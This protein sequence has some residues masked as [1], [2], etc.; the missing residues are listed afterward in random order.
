MSK[1]VLKIRLTPKQKAADAS[2]ARYKILK[3]GRRVGKTWFEA[4]TMAKWSL[5]KRQGKFWYV[6]R[7]LGLG[8][9][10]FLPALLNLLPRD[11][12]ARF[13]ERELSVRLTNGSKIFVKSGEKEDN[14][15]GR[16][17]DGV[18]LDEAAFLKERL[19]DQ[20]I[21]PQLAHSKG[22]VLIASSPKKG[23]FTRMF[24]EAAAG[25]LANTFASHATIYDS[26]IDADEIEKIRQRTPEHTW[27]QEYMAE[28]L[29]DA[30]QVYDEFSKA[31]IY[32]P[33]ERFRDFASYPFV[34]G[35]DYGLEA[36]TGCDWIGISPE[37]YLVI[38]QEHAQ[39]G[40]DVPR[41]AQVINTKSA[42]LDIRANVL[43]RSAFRDEGTSMTSIAKLFAKE[44]ISCQ[45][46][47][48]D[49]AASVDIV[50]R[51]LRGDGETPWL[52][53]SSNCPKTIQ[54][55]QEWEHGDH[56]PDIGAGARYGIAHAVV[57]RLTKLSHAVP[58]LRQVQSSQ[59][60]DEQRLSI[61][62]APVNQ[63]STTFQWDH[64]AGVP[65]Y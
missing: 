63:G 48:K 62:K 42:G 28:E 13:D 59:L 24:N 14:L 43:D 34:R 60:T 30:G 1:I 65:N 39:K 53:V 41:H 25:K 3:W 56:E 40:W 35:M 4:Y 51:F 18:V 19:F 38:T 5:A 32:D 2:N 27:R 6:T 45:P 52:Y 54:A 55:F 36:E 49:V 10:E 12:V 61:G 31:N 37:G 29:A 33:A 11:H 17:L 46:S 50:K 64:S 26:T 15:R 44:G 9:D 20:V 8:R 21:S 23:W 7:T 57:R 47:E 22:P 16:A 58:I